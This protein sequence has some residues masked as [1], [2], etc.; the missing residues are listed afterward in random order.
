MVSHE[1]DW[2][3]CRFLKAEE[4]SWQNRRVTTHYMVK[5]IADLA[6][7]LKVSPSTLYKLCIEGRVSAANVA[8]HW[9]FRK[10]IIDNWLDEAPC[11]AQWAAKK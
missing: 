8:R 9:R 6:K 7:Y 3:P 1:A 11:D 5:T 10:D 2:R 4:N